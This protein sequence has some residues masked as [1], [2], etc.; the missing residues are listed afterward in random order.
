MTDKRVKIYKSVRMYIVN[1][2]LH[3]RKEGEGGKERKGDERQR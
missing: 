2:C 3:V 1:A